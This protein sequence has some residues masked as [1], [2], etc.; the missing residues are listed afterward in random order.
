MRKSAVRTMALG[1]SAATLVCPAG[2]IVYAAEFDD[3][4]TDTEFNTESNSENEAA[5]STDDGAISSVGDDVAGIEAAAAMA[6]EAAAVADNAVDSTVAITDAAAQVAYQALESADSAVEIVE[7]GSQAEAQEAIATAQ[8]SVDSAQSQVDIAKD[9]YDDAL[10]SYREAKADYDSAMSAYSDNKAQAEADL[11]QARQELAEK[12]AK[13][14][15][16][17]ALLESAQASLQEIYDSTSQYQYV[18]ADGNTVGLSQEDVDSLE[19]SGGA[20]RRYEYNG[21]Y[22]TRDALVALGLSDDD[23][24]QISYTYVVLGDWSE[25]TTDGLDSETTTYSF[26]GETSE[27]TLVEEVIDDTKDAVVVSYFDANGNYVR[28]ITNYTTKY[29]YTYVNGVQISADGFAS[30]ADATDAA[31]SALSGYDVIATKINTSSYWSVSGTYAPRY[32]HNHSVVWTS[33]ITSK[34]EAVAIERGNAS[35]LNHLNNKFSESNGYTETSITYNYSSNTYYVGHGY[36]VTGNFTA[37]YDKLVDGYIKEYV[38]N[39]TVSGV[40]YDSEEEALAAVIAQAIADQYN[41]DTDKVIGIDQSNSSIDIDRLYQYYVD[42]I[43]RIT[44]SS[45]DS[46]TETYTN[47]SYTVTDFSDYL[48]DLRQQLQQYQDLIEDIAQAQAEVDEAQL[49]LQEY[50]DKISGMN[51]DDSTYSLAVVAYWQMQLEKARNNYD[52]AILDLQ[53]AR[54]NL[55]LAQS[56]YDA[57]YTVFSSDA[58]TSDSSESIFEIVEEMEEELEEEELEEEELEDEPEDT[59]V[60]EDAD[61]PLSGAHSGGALATVDLEDILPEVED[62]ADTDTSDNS[63]DTSDSIEITK[64]GLLKR[65]WWATFIAAPTAGGIGIV[66]LEAKRKAAEIAAELIDK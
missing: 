23:I 60:I 61:T 24:Q 62:I 38:I 40:K 48:K 43:Y 13:L 22:Y 10:A 34:N 42:Y 3:V 59:I 31:D 12:Q 37:E 44:E 53:S 16:Q 19:A 58:S 32:R 8:A 35:N 15:E 52:K 6:D 51:K 21:S 65:A 26:N 17:K 7:G 66:V 33:G 57:K 64:E 63:S 27:A 28:K 2:G 20:V 30:E 11:N 46:Y 5:S 9:E 45:D 41:T 4:V 49:R 56:N 39:S 18:D 14:A 47:Y 55:T 54:D 1:L 36:T 25:A 29:V 50:E